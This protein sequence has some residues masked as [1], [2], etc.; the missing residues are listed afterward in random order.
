MPS[1]AELLKDRKPFSFSLASS[2]SRNYRT[3]W[4]YCSLFQFVEG[5]DWRGDWTQ[6]TRQIGSLIPPIVSGVP[7]FFEE[8]DKERQDILSNLSERDFLP[9]RE[10]LAKV[11][12]ESSKAIRNF[13][14][15]E[16]LQLLSI[17][18]LETSRAEYK[19]YTTSFSYLED[20]GL[21]QISLDLIH[22]IKLIIDKAKDV[23]LHR[24]LVLSQRLA[25]L[26]SES[27]ILLTKTCSVYSD[28]AKLAEEHLQSIVEQ[29]PHI[30]W[31]QQFL[32]RL[33]YLIENVGSA[34]SNPLIVRCFIDFYLIQL[35]DKAELH[36]EIH[37]LTSNYPKER[38]LSKKKPKT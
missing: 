8:M 14:S 10:A 28:A 9:Y 36:S 25:L 7:S 4:Y 17:Y 18:Y 24:K 34:I 23:L 27:L 21:P 32:Q 3:F 35:K 13:P 15:A 2:E 31:N 33:F 37:S 22:C 38:C 16:V 1:F 26:E 11:L 19:N 30:S 29:Y 20:P 12:P 6:A 5:G